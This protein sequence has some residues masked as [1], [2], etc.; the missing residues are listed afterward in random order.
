VSADFS[1]R[2]SDH[3]P[4]REP[5]K[6]P[7]LPRMLT[8]QWSRREVGGADIASHICRQLSLLSALDTN[9]PAL[10]PLL[11]TLKD[12]LEARVQRTGSGTSDRARSAGSGKRQHFESLTAQRSPSRLSR[13]F[14]R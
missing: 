12:L 7:A 13:R 10:A 14:S 1:P 5:Q 8:F 9:F 2:S 3:L 11:A 4:P 6:N